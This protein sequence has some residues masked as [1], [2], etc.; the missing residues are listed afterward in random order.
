[1]NGAIVEGISVGSTVVK[2]G[3]YIDIGTYD[4]IMELEVAMKK[5]EVS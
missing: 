1:M 3:S 4:E 2:R 5:G